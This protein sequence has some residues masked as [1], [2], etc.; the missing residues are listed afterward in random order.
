MLVGF[1]G[2]LVAFF[3][4]ALAVVLCG[5]VMV[6]GCFSVVLSGFLVRFVCHFEFSCGKSPGAIL[7]AP[8]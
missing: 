2:V 4:V 3:V 1:G 8:L 7:R 6:L 5:Q